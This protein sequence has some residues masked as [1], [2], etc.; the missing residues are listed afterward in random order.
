MTKYKWSLL[1]LAV[2]VMLFLVF[3]IDPLITFIK[4]DKT[5]PAEKIPTEI[6]IDMMERIETIERE[7]FDSGIEFD[8]REQMEIEKLVNTDYKEWYKSVPKKVDRN[9]LKIS[10]IKFGKSFYHWNLFWIPIIV[11]S[12]LAFNY[13]K[14]DKLK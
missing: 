7:L 12:F 1:G 3:M 5:I 14:S 10:L 9:L 6:Y 4:V 11:F 13:R 8:H 2:S